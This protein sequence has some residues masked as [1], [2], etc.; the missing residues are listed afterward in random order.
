[1]QCAV[2]TDRADHVELLQLDDDTIVSACVCRGLRSWSETC[3]G[4]SPVPE[5]R[6]VKGEVSGEPT[7]TKT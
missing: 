2:E 6:M 1:M 5:C 4:D 3:T 7:G